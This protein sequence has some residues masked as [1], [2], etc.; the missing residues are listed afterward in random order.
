MADPLAQSL[1][2]G[3]PSAFAELYDRFAARLV[4]TARRMGCHPAATE[5]IVHDLFVAMARSRAN[6]E[7]VDNL[8]A[9]VF[10]ESKGRASGAGPSARPDCGLIIR[11]VN[12]DQKHLVAADDRRQVAFATRIFEEADTP[13][14][15]VA[16]AAVARADGRCACH[17]EDPLPA[18][19][20]MPATHPVWRE[21]EEPPLRGPG[22]WRNIE[23]GCR[24][25]KLLRC[26]RHGRRFEVRLAGF[27]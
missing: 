15:E 7:N 23:G 3:T 16:L 25:G 11:D 10:T 17:H 13:R 27:V 5:D 9:Y 20:A 19:T 6:F 4:K 1:A 2:A 12:S 14:L 21:A 26:H 22:R 18:G 8:D 24:R